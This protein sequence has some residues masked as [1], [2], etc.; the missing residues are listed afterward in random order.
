M[1][2]FIS[3]ARLVVLGIA[4]AATL[5]GCIG[6]QL[7]RQPVT[8]PPTVQRHIFPPIEQARTDIASALKL[9]RRTHKNVL[10]DFGADWCGDCQVLNIY[11]HQAPNEALLA[12]HFV[13]VDVNIGREDANLDIA[14]HYGV[15]VHGV[16]A[17]AVLRPDGRV[18]VAQDKEFSSM[19]YMQSSAVTQFLQRWKP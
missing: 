14:H 8:Q 4:C 5:P 11:F 10:L 9:A 6:A 1:S 3:S 13:L 16:P 17:L 15:P 19:R 7:I 2:V 12:R 18:L